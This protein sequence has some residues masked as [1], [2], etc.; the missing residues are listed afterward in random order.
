VLAV[1]ELDSHRSF[2]E[3]SSLAQGDPKRL[4]VRPSSHAWLSLCGFD[5]MIAS[6]I[7]TSNPSRTYRLSGRFRYLFT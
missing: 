1:G 4:Y 5:Y 7:E 3:I 6:E 2:S